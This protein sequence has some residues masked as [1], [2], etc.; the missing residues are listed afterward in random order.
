MTASSIV[1]GTVASLIAVPLGQRPLGRVQRLGRAVRHPGDDGIL[2]RV[3]DDGLADRVPVR[4][5]FGA[6]CAEELLD[7]EW[8]PIGPFE[9]GR[10]HVSWRRQPGVEDEGRCQ[11]RFRLGERGEPGL[12]RDPL[13]DEPCPPVSKARARRDV[14]DP[15]VAGQEQRPVA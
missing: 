8:D 14:V 12:L 1:S 5:G 6:Q 4:S 3:R 7:M 10:R 15:V 11:G 9:H 13:G 2:D